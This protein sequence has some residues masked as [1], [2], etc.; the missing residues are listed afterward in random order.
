MPRPAPAA[1]IDA[2]IDERVLG[3]G[4]SVRFATLLLLLLAASGS[5]MLTVVL[6]LADGDRTGC[7]LAAGADPSDPSWTQSA[8]AVGQAVA[9]HLCQSAWAPPPPWWQIVGWPF[10]LTASSVLLFLLLPR[11]KARASRVVPLA[12]VDPDGELGT[13]IAGLAADTGLAPVPRV[14]VDPAATGS[15]AVV[16]GRTGRPVVCLYGGLLVDRH[17]D[18][19]RL[20]AVLLHELAHVANRD[21][22][23]T[24]ATVTL[25]RVFLALVL[26]PYLLWEGHVVQGVLAD[27]RMPVLDRPMLLAAFTVA[28]VHLARSDVL[29]S[30]EVYADLTALRWGADPHGWA[31]ESPQQAAGPRRRVLAPFLAPFLAPLRTHPQW[32]LRRGALTDPAPLFRTP[33]AAFFL[34]GATVMLVDQHLLYYLA[35]YDLATIGITQAITLLSAAL[36][37]SIAGISLWRAVAYAVL[38]GARV[39]SGWWAGGWLGAGIAAGTVLTSSGGSG[40]WLP[41]RPQL[42][43]LPVAVGMAFG[44]WIAQCAHLWTRTWRGRTLRPALLLGLGAVVPALGLWLAWWHLMGTLYASGFTARAAGVTQWVYAWFPT[45]V[46]GGD[47]GRVPG[48]TTVVPLLGSITAIFLIP[49]A[50]TALW[51]VP[52]IAWAVGPAEGRPRWHPGAAGDLVASDRVVPAGGVVPSLRRVLV[53]G[54][55]GGVLACTAFVGV[56]AHL[57]TGQPVPGAR[58]GLYALRYTAGTLLALAGPAGLAALAAAGRTGRFRLV[59]ALI[60]AQSAVVLGFLGITVL[61][62]L[63]GCAG[64]LSVLQDSCAWRP[65]WQLRLFPFLYLLNVALVLSTVL[66]TALSAACA[67]ASA[68]LRRIRPARPRRPATRAPDRVA[69]GPRVV[70][71]LLCAV[72][73][74]LSGTADASRIPAITFT[75]DLAA[76]QNSTSQL[77]AVPGAPVSAATRARQ[78]D[79][80]YRLGGDTVLDQLTAR[81]TQL[82][83]A[84]RAAQ[85][86]SWYSLDRQLRPACEQWERAALYE[87]VWFRVPDRETQADWHAVAVHAGQGG[88]RCTAA[89]TARDQNALLSGLR[90]LIAAGRCTASVNARIDAVLRADGRKG[91]VRPPAQGTTCERA[92]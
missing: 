44:W 42:L 91:T 77:A 3:A 6:G 80:W 43:L 78:V 49:L 27:G 70:A 74:G 62:S 90:E 46:L 2:R 66:A 81:S 28:L 13:L 34:I 7:E 47:P 82:T 19:T 30:R 8:L 10:L 9:Y 45:A 4:T 23:L 5:M 31:G 92:G 64:P 57:H 67:L 40:V 71:G 85:G 22:T 20:R 24:Y 36:V 87:T 39:P 35:P 48:V 12:A 69:R 59:G 73:V 68:A 14:V 37:T 84:I 88:R 33:T 29:R 51:V 76:S 54:V 26:L 65:A 32:G 60:A 25:W 83:A 53:P 1:R 75:V 50:L 61:A 18:P 52:L 89:L 79:A 16:F 41:Q 56:Q 72:A 21:I 86:G 55:L 15:G 38:T 11:W 63:D 58:G 17:R